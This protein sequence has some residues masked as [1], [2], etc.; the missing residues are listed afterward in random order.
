MRVFHFNPFKSMTL[1]GTAVALGS[2]VWAHLDPTAL[3]PVGQVLVQAAG[4]LWAAL[5]ARNAIAK[6]GAGR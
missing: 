4:V 3:T 1:Q 5:G 6:N 2:Y